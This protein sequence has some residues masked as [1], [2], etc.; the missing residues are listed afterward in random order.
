MHT[1]IHKSTV[2]HF[3]QKFHGRFFRNS[4]LQ[5]VRKS[6]GTMNLYR[7]SSQPPH[8]IHHDSQRRH[9]ALSQEDFQLKSCSSPATSSCTKHELHV[10]PVN[11]ISREDSWDNEVVRSKTW[12]N[13]IPQYFYSVSNVGLEGST[14][15]QSAPRFRPDD[16]QWQMGF[17]CNEKALFMG[18]SYET[19]WP[20][21]KFYI[22]C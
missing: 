21:R 16:F 19:R 20:S 7:N 2:I 4:K 1:S 10:M 11:S 9:D 22:W 12:F 14:F 3:I 5:H 18:T 6:R 8:V 17:T 13:I 15:E